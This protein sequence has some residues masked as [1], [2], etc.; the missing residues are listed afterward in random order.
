MSNSMVINATAQEARIAVLEDGVIADFHQERRDAAGVVGNI[1]HGRV[2]RVLPGMQAAFVDI[3]L[4]KAAF[5]YVADIY[6]DHSILEMPDRSGEDPPDEESD[7]RGGGRMRR[8][9]KHA[10]IEDQLKEG[11]DI[12]VQ[13]TKDPISTKGARLTCHISLAGRYLVYMPTV[14]HIGISKQIE[15]DKDRRRLR[16]IA[17]EMLPKGSGFIVRT[18]SKDVRNALL[19]RD[20]EVL[21]NLWNDIYKRSRKS[22][23]PTCLHTDL[24]M[25]L[26]CTRD[27]AA[28]NL[29][30]LVVDSRD[31]YER[32]MDFVERFMPR[33]ANR[34]ELYVGT[35]PIFDAF[36]IEDE[37]RRALN[38]NANLPSGGSLVIEQTEALTAID[39]NT[40]RFVG[41]SNL[42]ETIVQTN[43]EAADEIAYQ[44]R[45]RNLGG[46]VVIDFID[47]NSERDRR[48][49]VERLRRA[50]GGDRSRVKV[51]EI[52]G[53]GLCTMTR[54]RTS[55]SLERMMCEPCEHCEGRGVTLSAQTLAY[56][57]LRRLR[58]RLE[59]IDAF[60]IRIVAHPTVARILQRDE[61]QSIRNL[62]LRFNKK[63]R[64][65]TDR[66]RHIEQVDIVT[67]KPGGGATR[68]AKAG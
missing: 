18:A 55:E 50:M 22:K 35:E 33:F 10:P 4:E 21:I 39:I 6:Q 31:E 13:V 49:V 26:R 64:V 66:S 16:R 12:L 59:V 23:P 46:L 29:D 44:L 54:K 9:R 24:D 36:G 7:S 68:N 11:Q 32:I 62:E 48:K 1:Y 52:S 57:T 20:M 61:K 51:S 53:F 27:L 58:R 67:E 17:H 8:N 56:D 28:A 60:D 63:L 2:V 65:V 38:K 5:L 45:L 14:D 30:R 37:L 42:E 3:G 19:R 34:V 41:E 40:G 25:T 47:M 15:S 43:L